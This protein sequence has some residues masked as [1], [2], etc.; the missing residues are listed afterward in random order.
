MFMICPVRCTVELD[1]SQV[2]TSAG[3][4]AYVSGNVID[5]NPVAVVVSVTAPAWMPFS[6]FTTGTTAYSEVFDDADIISVPYTAVL[7]DGEHEWWDADSI[8]PMMQESEWSDSVGDQTLCWDHW[9]ECDYCQEPMSRTLGE[10]RDRWTCTT[11]ALKH[12][13]C[14]RNFA[15]QYVDEGYTNNNGDWVEV[16]TCLLCGHIQREGL[17]RDNNPTTPQ[18]G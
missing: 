13:K 16:I 2:T 17:K 4:D 9:I 8:Q 15:H 7:T 3:A 6:L 10:V 1:S 12:G 5:T 18:K 14:G 11:C